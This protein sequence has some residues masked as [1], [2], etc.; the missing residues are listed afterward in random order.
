MLHWE[1]YG[2]TALHSQQLKSIRQAWKTLHS[3]LKWPLRIKS[4]FGG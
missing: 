4:I 3:P 1:V 2:E